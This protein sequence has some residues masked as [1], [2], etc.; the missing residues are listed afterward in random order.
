LLLITHDMNLAGRCD[1]IV[2]IADGL[3]V[4]DERTPIGLAA[5]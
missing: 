5:Q 1:R 3:I 4:S 2:H